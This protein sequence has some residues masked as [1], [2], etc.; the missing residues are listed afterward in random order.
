MGRASDR[1]GHV[2]MAGLD[3]GTAVYYADMT[4]VRRGEAMG[5]RKG[6]LPKTIGGVK[7]PK[8][9]RKQARRL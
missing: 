1:S 3:G 6:K 9:V 8:A 2:I 5:K 4:A 7:L